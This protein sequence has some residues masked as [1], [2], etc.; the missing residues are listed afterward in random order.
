M[1]LAIS[2]VS[3]KKGLDKVV[4]PVV[5]NAELLY[6][7]C[8]QVYSEEFRGYGIKEWYPEANQGRGLLYSFYDDSDYKII[9]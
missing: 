8:Y 7:G 6:E 3:G 5:V 1:K 9:L 2:C 4:L